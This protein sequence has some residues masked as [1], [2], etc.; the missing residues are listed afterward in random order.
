M[1]NVCVSVCV[2]VNVRS[3]CVKNDIA[4]S[5][6]NVYPQRSEAF[7]SIKPCGPSY[8]NCS[9][10]RA[11][12]CDSFNRC[13]T[14]IQ[15]ILCIFETNKNLFNFE[16]SIKFSTE[17]YLIFDSENCAISLKI[18]NFKVVNVGSTLLITSKWISGAALFANSMRPIRS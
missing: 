13:Y 6:S 5:W 11:L 18:F 1:F 3:D 8:V 10:C 14:H 12:Y 4:Q 2:C 7:S 16:I 15:L 9:D 17:T